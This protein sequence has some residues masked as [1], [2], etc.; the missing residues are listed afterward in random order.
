MRSDNVRGNSCVNR[1]EVFNSVARKS[2]EEPKDGATT[3]RTKRPAKTD[4][5][6]GENV[7]AHDPSDQ[8]AGSEPSETPAEAPQTPEDAAKAEA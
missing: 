6:A 2:L 4:D 3:A 8:P 1:D 7:V 5:K